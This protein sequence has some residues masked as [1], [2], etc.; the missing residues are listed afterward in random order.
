MK[1]L[2]YL[3]VLIVAATLCG[4]AEPKKKTA[5]KAPPAAAAKTELVDINTATQK[6]LEDLPGIGPVYAGKIIAGRPYRAKNQLVQKKIIP[7][8]TYEKV[9][10]MIIAKQGTK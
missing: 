8:A 4:A 7:E 6:Q 5:P 9:K 3:I 10:D 2:K 1:V